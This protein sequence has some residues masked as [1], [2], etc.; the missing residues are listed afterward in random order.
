MWNL[1]TTSAHRAI[2]GLDFP[3]QPG[4]SSRADLRILSRKPERSSARR[5]LSP[6]RRVTMASIHLPLKWRSIGRPSS[7]IMLTPTT[8]HMRLVPAR[9]TTGTP[10]QRASHVVAVP[11]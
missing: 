10:I 1:R 5:A 2:G 7:V 4:P 11:W 8:R 3:G 9:V 6:A